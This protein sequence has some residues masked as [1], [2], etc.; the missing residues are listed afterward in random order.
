MKKNIFFDYG[1][2][3]SIEEKAKL[4]KETGF[5]GVFLF[6]DSLFE[7]KYAMAVKYGLNVET[8]H[9]PFQKV[10]NLLWI[11][12]EMQNVKAREYVE[13]IKK[14]IRIASEKHID[15]V[16][17]HLS[18]SLTPPPINKIGFERILEILSECEKYNVYLALENLRYLEYLDETLANVKSKYLICCFDSGHANCFTKN[19]ES[20]DFEKYKGL[21]K[22]L[23][24]HDNHGENDEH[25]IPFMGNIDFKKVM[26]KLK[27]INYDG[28]LTLEIINSKSDYYLNKTLNEKEYLHMAL[29]AIKKIED[30]FNE[31]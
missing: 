10:C 29:S 19:I 4:I 15:K 18:Q 21:I 16:V 12:D 7:E 3:S 1:Y 30:Y 14:W 5:D 11:D 6:A 22:C 23:H 8:I 25:L 17:F 26:Y 24:L 28:Q 31:A 13:T 2:N 27:K 9:L 20:Y